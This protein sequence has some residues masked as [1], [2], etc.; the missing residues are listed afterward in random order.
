MEQLVEDMNSRQQVT[1]K[2]LLVLNIDVKDSYQEAAKAAP[3]A[4]KL[5]EMVSD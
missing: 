5:C 1:M 2:P 4:A 3:L